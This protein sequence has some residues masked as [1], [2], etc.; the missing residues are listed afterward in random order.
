MRLSRYHK[1]N[2]VKTKLNCN[3]NKNDY[4]KILLNKNGNAEKFWV[5]IENIIGK[6]L[7]GEVDNELY[8]NFGI[9]YKSKVC[10]DKSSVIDIDKYDSKANVDQI[11]YL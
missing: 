1:I 2:P 8:G 11:I 4:V 3:V 7:F 10:F 5:K 9:G 6:K